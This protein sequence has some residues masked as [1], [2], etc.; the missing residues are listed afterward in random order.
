MRRSQR[1]TVKVADYRVLQ[2][3]GK[4]DSNMRTS[5]T[6]EQGKDDGA[7]NGVMGGGSTD[8]HIMLEH[9][10]RA[11]Q[12]RL[13]AETQR[14]ELL[15]LKSENIALQAKLDESHMLREQYE[16]TLSGAEKAHRVSC[17]EH[18]ARMAA[19]QDIMTKRKE[20]YLRSMEDSTINE[21]S[22]VRDWLD[23]YYGTAVDSVV[24][25]KPSNTTK[26]SVD[27]NDLTPQ[28]AKDLLLKLTRDGS[29]RT[30]PTTG[31]NFLDSSTDKILG[32]S[33]PSGVDILDKL[34]LWKTIPKED[35]GDDGES[36]S[37]KN[38]CGCK[39]KKKLKSGMLDKATANIEHKEIWPQKNLVEDYAD[40]ELD[41]KQMQFEHFVA[42]ESRTIELCTDKVQCVGQLRLLRRISYLKLQGNEWPCIRTM[43]AAILHSIETGEMSWDPN[44]DRFEGIL[45]GRPKLSKSDDPKTR[46]KDPS[47]TAPVKDWYCRAYNKPEGCPEGKSHWARIANRDRFVQHICASC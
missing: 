7:S 39:H 21:Q 29:L 46:R 17:N 18:A 24:L 23:K 37:S 35:P 34:G 20:E 10:N 9:D 40:A 30:C 15:R 28:Q 14:N 6:V 44:F 13:N 36:V 38:S 16:L 3:S 19:L 25:P 1:E 5:G 22:K 4:E 2:N 45:N 11:L 26:K 8:A 32:P 41:F 43:Y 31:V 33:G 12:D 42:G 27:P 47:A